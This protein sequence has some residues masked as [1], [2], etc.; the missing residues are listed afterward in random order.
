MTRMNADDPKNREPIAIVGMGC[1]FPGGAVDP[2]SYWNLLVNGVDAI[3]EIPPDRWDVDT[4]YHAQPG[5]SGKSYARRGGF[6][7]D[8]DQFE[9]ECFRI[10]PREAA[11][12]DPQQRLLLEVVW[13]A[14]EDA[15]ISAT[16]F[17]G[18]S[19]GVFVGISTWDYA[20]IQTS[21]TDQRALSSF[22]AL[23]TSLS[24]A[25]NRISYCF[26]LHGPSMAVDTACSSSLVAV[27]RALSSLRNGECGMAIAGGVNVI[28]APETVISYCAASLLS[29]EGRCAAFDAGAT[30]FVRGEGAGVVL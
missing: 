10:S 15:G 2:A 28:T 22:S 19:T 7:R 4:F 12:M 25:A 11:F 8:I 29:P 27:D 24:I 20:Q 6:I 3:T 26:D 9:P 23:G 14:L 21:P 1:R 30:G 5:T 18:S 17:E 16:R 13:E